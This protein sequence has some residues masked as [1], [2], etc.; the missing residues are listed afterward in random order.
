MTPIF[1]DELKIMAK[2]TNTDAAEVTVEQYLNIRKEAGLGIDPA[3]A[4][5]GVAEVGIDGT[6]YRSKR[7]RGPSALCRHHG[8]SPF[9]ALCSD[10]LC[11]R[12]AIRRHQ[13]HQAVPNV[14]HD[15]VESWNQYQRNEC[16]KQ[17]SKSQRNGH[18]NQKL[19]LH[20]LLE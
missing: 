12:L 19:R 6:I 11:V 5:V 3:T 7:V 17:N 9:S 16:S 1:G 18:R 2:Q 10:F 8:R 14:F 13:P 20:A 4:E 15:G